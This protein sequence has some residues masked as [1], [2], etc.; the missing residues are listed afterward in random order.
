MISRTP[1]QANAARTET[2][3]DLMI[4]SSFGFWAFLLGLA[5]VL[6]ISLFGGH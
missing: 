4:V 5:P 6:A 3:R 2:V 1:A